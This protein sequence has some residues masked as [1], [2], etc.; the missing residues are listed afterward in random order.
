MVA[1]PGG[2]RQL[3]RRGALR[4]ARTSVYD[5]PSRSSLVGPERSSL[6]PKMRVVLV[7]APQQTF[8]G[9]QLGLPSLAAVLREAGVAVTLRDLNLEFNRSLLSPEGLRRAAGRARSRFGAAGPP[10][11]EAALAPLD[12]LTEQLPRALRALSEPATLRD[13]AALQAAF[14]VLGEAYALLSAP[15]APG[16]LG[17]GFSHPRPVTQWRELDALVADPW[18]N[19]FQDWCDDA[20]IDSL[21]VGDPGLVG[22]SLTY[23][24]QLVATLT[25]ARRL[26]ERRADLRLVLGGALATRLGPAFSRAGD[27]FSPF[28]WVVLGEGETALLHLVTCLSEGRAPDASSPN[29]LLRR[30]GG[31]LQRGPEHSEDLAALPCPDFRD[32]DLTGYLLPQAVLPLLTSRGCYWGRCAFCGHHQSYGKRRFRAR[33][34][35]RLRDD[36]R[37]LAERHGSRA[38]YLVDEALP[39]RSLRLLAEEAPRWG[40]EWF[41]DV[42][43]EP[44][45]DRS[46][47][48]RLAQGGCRM[49]IFGLESGSQRVLDSMCKGVDLAVAERILEDCASVDIVAAV[50]AFVGFPGETLPEAQAT[51]A[52][53]RRHAARLGTV[54]LGSFSL[55]EGS[56]A[57][58][59]PAAF[60]ITWV[61]DEPEDG[62]L[63]ARYSYRSLRGIDAGSAARIAEALRRQFSAVASP[64]A[65]LPRELVAQRPRASATQEA[66]P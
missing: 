61:A 26:R 51:A 35:A 6:E 13:D 10:A 7:Q 23:E 66:C 59:D 22:F 44:W 17:Q 14:G 2:L 41:G 50:M 40:F 3:P 58:R 38:L 31:G 63:G 34:A 45:L 53:L 57:A 36:L 47:L 65:W 39:P 52:L 27:F 8:Y 11:V 25:V 20:L 1:Q 5:L 48:E 9:P 60:G 30:P 33:P 29:L 15:C 42:R 62:D 28:D 21:L 49:L 43:L 4:R 37:T 56:P 64:S 32:L 46:L 19:P 55:V 18:E 54:G 24:D 12:A 16:S